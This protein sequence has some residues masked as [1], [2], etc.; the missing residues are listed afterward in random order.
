[1]TTY[2]F[3]Q[4]V[5][6]F[7]RSEDVKYCHFD[8]ETPVIVSLTPL[9]ILS[10]RHHPRTKYLW[11]IYLCTV[12]SQETFPRNSPCLTK[13]VEQNRSYAFCVLSPNLGPFRSIY[14]ESRA[15]SV[16]NYVFNMYLLRYIAHTS[17][18]LFHV[19]PL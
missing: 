2:T 13:L 7:L 16:I 14:F 1:M 5:K 17:D 19:G 15:S 10:M 11:V 12:T 3:S 9:W 18:L 6:T 8:K 4:F